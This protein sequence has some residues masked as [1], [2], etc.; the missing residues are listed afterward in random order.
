MLEIAN[1]IWSWLND[2]YSGTVATLAFAATTAQAIAFYI[3]NKQSVRPYLHVGFYE[4]NNDICLVL[5]N[6]GLGPAIIEDFG[7]ISDGIYYRDEEIIE[8]F[9]KKDIQAGVRSF[10]PGSAITAGSRLDILTIT[11]DEPTKGFDYY[12]SYIIKNF[13]LFIKYKSFRNETIHYN[14]QQHLWPAK[15]RVHKP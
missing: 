5:E 13:E 2:N 12:Q 1:S 3:Q 9:D 8:A 14:S 15:R 10:L 11:L 4:V 7:I 6:S